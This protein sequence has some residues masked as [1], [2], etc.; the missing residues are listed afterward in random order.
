MMSKSVRDRRSGRC[1]AILCEGLHCSRVLMQKLRQ[2]AQLDVMQEQH[3]S[4]AR[5][6][7]I[8]QRLQDA[9]Q[10]ASERGSS[11][12]AEPLPGARLDD[13]VDI[14]EAIEAEPSKAPQVLRGLS[15][16]T[17]QETLQYAQRR[18]E[19]LQMDAAQDMQKE[20]DVSRMMKANERADAHR[21]NDVLRASHAVSAL[22]ECATHT[23]AMARAG[24]NASSTSAIQANWAKTS[25]LKASGTW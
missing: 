1:V 16:D 11:I 22:S 2:S 12:K 25:L 7:E 17:L 9:L 5:I 10:T 3:K 24:A 14:F 6:L 4:A 21:S 15:K 18:M 23:S 8:Q 13:F 20:L 19:S